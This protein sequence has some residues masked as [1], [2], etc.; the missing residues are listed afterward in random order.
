MPSVKR[1]FAACGKLRSILDESAETPGV[2]NCDGTRWSRFFRTFRPTL[3]RRGV[4]LLD[5]FGRAFFAFILRNVPKG[6]YLVSSLFL[7][8]L[9]LILGYVWFVPPSFCSDESSRCYALR[10]QRL[11][12]AH[13][14][15]CTS[16]DHFRSTG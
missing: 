11:Q 6:F 9:V 3:D 2:H 16:I 5:C 14:L 8:S 15:R 7:L 4:H 13:S 10:F 12:V 1:P